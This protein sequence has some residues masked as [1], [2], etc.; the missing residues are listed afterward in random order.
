VSSGGR[1]R[2]CPE[3]AR[4]EG[5]VR[6]RTL[7]VPGDGITFWPLAEIVRDAGRID[8]DDPRELAISK[9]ADLTGDPELTERL[10]AAMGLTDAVFSLQETFWA[11]RSLLE[12]L[13]YARPLVVAI[14][15]IH[16]PRGR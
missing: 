4:G 11:A 7:P 8:A 3:L 5:G 1:R 10:C 16:W 12:R 14:D 13:A 9:V 6:A 15:D 2:G